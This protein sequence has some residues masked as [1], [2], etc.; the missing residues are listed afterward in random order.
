MNW[1]LRSHSSLR[2]DVV[3]EVSMAIAIIEYLHAPVREFIQL[4]PFDIGIENVENCI[5]FSV[6]ERLVKSF[7][8]IEVIHI[9][10]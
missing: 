8:N 4:V 5:D 10:R 6:L 2:S 7:D 3:W 1:I 9:F